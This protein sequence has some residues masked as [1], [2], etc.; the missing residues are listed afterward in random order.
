MIRPRPFLASLLVGLAVAPACAQILPPGTSVTLLDTDF[1]FTEGPLYD[2]VG[3]VYFSDMW[4]ANTQATLPSKIWRYDIAADTSQVVDPNS[5]TSNGLILD[6]G[7]HVISADRDRRQVSRRS[8]GNITMVETALANNWMGALFNG[9]NDLVMDAAGG[10]FFTDP[11]YEN[12]R[13]TPEALYYIGP[14]GALSR[15][16]TFPATGSNRRPNGVAL[17]PN[18]SVLYLAVEMNKRIMAYDVSAGGAI[19]NERLFA[20]TNVNGSGTPLP[21]ITNGPDGIAIDAAG[22]VY[23]AVQN[24]VFAWNPAGQRL[25]DLPVPQ[26][27]TNLKFGGVDGRTLFITAGR[28]LYGIELNVPSPAL[29]DF[30]GDAIVD[31]IDYTVW[32]DTLG[33]SMNLSADANGNRTID[34]GDYDVWKTHFGNTLGSGAGAIT[35]LVSGNSPGTSS[36]VPEPSG[37]GLAIIGL[38][39][40]LKVRHR[41]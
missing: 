25:F 40:C 10:I 19:S 21:G 6:S 27:P 12:R 41:S 33:T 17:S 3:G 36:T 1:R 13:S 22:N 37:L 2:G 18:G 8:A 9:P 28:S 31:A 38:L 39:V 15:L 11:D 32:R 20:L 7:G 26:D 5:G 30:N 14:A 4:P 23:C 16:L 34:A 29:G 24:A 35:Q